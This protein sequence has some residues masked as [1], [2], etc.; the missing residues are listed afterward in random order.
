[1]N[2]VGRVASRPYEA[3]PEDFDVDDCPG[4]FHLVEFDWIRLGQIE[5]VP[6]LECVGS[7]SGPEDDLV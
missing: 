2:M 1:M 3:S 7:A 5:E 6:N 4:L